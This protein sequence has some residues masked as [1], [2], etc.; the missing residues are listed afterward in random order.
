MNVGDAVE[1]VLRMPEFAPYAATLKPLLIE[2]LQ[3]EERAWQAGKHTSSTT[4]AIE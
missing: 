3:Q 4:T 1:R 2:K